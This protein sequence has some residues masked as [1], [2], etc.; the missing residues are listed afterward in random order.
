MIEIDRVHTPERATRG[1]WQA[2]HI[3]DTATLISEVRCGAA[4]GGS[5]MNPNSEIA[6]ASLKFENRGMAAYIGDRG[7]GIQ[8][9]VDM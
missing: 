9:G 4:A 5:T 8:N 7:I 3:P 1:G 6:R 2:T